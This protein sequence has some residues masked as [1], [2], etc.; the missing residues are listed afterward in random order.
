M[1]LVAR[2]PKPK[3]GDVQLQTF[4]SAA[5]HGALATLAFCAFVD[6]LRAK[7]GDPLCVDGCL[8]KETFFIP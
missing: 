5:A 2:S 3:A 4:V 1:K 6:W 7:A 8:E